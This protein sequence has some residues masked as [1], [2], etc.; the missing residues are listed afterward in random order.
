MFAQ[1]TCSL[2]WINLA[3]SL[4][5]LVGSAVFFTAFNGRRGKRLYNLLVAAG[6]GKAAATMLFYPMVSGV[7][8]QGPATVLPY[9]IFATVVSGAVA[10][11]AFIAGLV[12]ATQACPIDDRTGLMYA[13]YI[14][15]LDMGDSVGGWMTAP[16]V[17]SLGISDADLSQLGSLVG[18]DAGSS[19]LA[20]A[21]TPL[22]YF[23]GSSADLRRAAARSEAAGDTPH[24]ASDNRDTSD[25]NDNGD[26][27]TE[28]VALLAH[29][30]RTVNGDVI[31]SDWENAGAVEGDHEQAL[32]LLG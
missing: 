27:C 4:S 25:N 16:V 13:L 1:D 9:A 8:A 29:H 24:I 23:A 3:S 21:V 30:A 26:G 14:S 28:Q 7:L 32:P 5:K 18:I 11:V 17:S 22:L 20:L 19:L 6:I 10:Q 31:V 2:Q 12:L 15:F